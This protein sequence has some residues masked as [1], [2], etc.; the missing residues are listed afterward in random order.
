M[1]LSSRNLRRIRQ[2][3]PGGSWK[4]WDEYLVNPCHTATYYPA[5]YGRLRWDAPAPTIT[6][7]FC[8]YST[9]RFGHPE[10]DRAISVREGALLQTFPADYDLIEGDDP[11]LIC[12]L[13]RHI[14]KLSLFS[15][16]NKFAAPSKPQ[17]ATQTPTGP[18]RQFGPPPNALQLHPADPY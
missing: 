10:Q 6:T 9:G 14:G 2:S 13:A 18:W 12:N 5:P 7:Q 4:D 17:N 1:P 15:I 8:Y 3:R 11:F 16:A